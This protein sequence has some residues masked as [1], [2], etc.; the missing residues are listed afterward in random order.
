MEIDENSLEN[1]KV[2][3]T[4]LSPM[5]NTGKEIF[6]YKNF[7]PKIKIQVGLC[8][9]KKRFALQKKKNHSLFKLIKKNRG[10]F[11]KFLIYFHFF[12]NKYLFFFIHANL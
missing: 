5:R 9:I 3:E 8:V 1:E 11:F 4:F 10:F 6:I 12:A 7:S 2:N